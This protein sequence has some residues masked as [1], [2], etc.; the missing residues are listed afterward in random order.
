MNHVSLGNVS[1]AS[2]GTY[3]CK[4]MTDVPTFDEDHQDGSVEVFSACKYYFLGEVT[5]HGL[6][7]KDFMRILADISR[8]LSCFITKLPDWKD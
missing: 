6:D 7:D 8:I 2:A 1:L 5:K 4:V 3:K